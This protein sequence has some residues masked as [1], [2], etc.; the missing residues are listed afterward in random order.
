VDILLEKEPALKINKNELKRLFS[1]ATAESHFLI[2]GNIYE[3]VDG[4]S[5][6]FPLAPVLTYRFMGYHEKN[7][8]NNRNAR[9]NKKF[10][11]RYPFRNGARPT[12]K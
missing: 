1:F 5:M 10:S 3:Q 9:G 2:E 8:L 6:R 11:S 7:W 4:V 12:N